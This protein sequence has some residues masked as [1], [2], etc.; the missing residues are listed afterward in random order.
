MGKSL[1]SKIKAKS[2]IGDKTRM[3]MSKVMDRSGMLEKSRYLDKS[4]NTVIDTSTKKISEK[5]EEQKI[6]N[7]KK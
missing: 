1:L 2:R 4:K 6:L 5:K 7:F 3:N